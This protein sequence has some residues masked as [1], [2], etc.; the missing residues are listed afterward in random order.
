MSLIEAIKKQIEAKQEWKDQ[1]KRVKSLPQEY[2]VV[3]KE[4]QNYLF[5][6]ASGDGMDT[7]KG[8]Y[9]LLE[10]FEEAA[11]NNI[12]VL[13]FTGEDV[14]EFAE[15]YRRSIGAKHWTDDLKTKME[16][17]IKNKLNK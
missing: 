3:F 7:V 6:F 13:E 9:D 14:G 15:N 4:M 11:A 12:S 10:M 5:Q 16:E 17:N 2:Q 1:M 8:I